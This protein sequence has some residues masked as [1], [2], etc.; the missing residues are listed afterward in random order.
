MHEVSKAARVALPLDAWRVLG[1]L[2]T[3][4]LCSLVL[5][6]YRPYFTRPPASAIVLMP[7]VS[8]GGVRPAA[9]RPQRGIGRTILPIPPAGKYFLPPFRCDAIPGHRHEFR[10]STYAVAVG[11]GFRPL[12]GVNISVHGEPTI[13]YLATASTCLLAPTTSLTCWNALPGFHYVARSGRTG[14]ARDGPPSMFVRLASAAAVL[15]ALVVLLA[16]ACRGPRWLPWALAG[17]GFAWLLLWYPFAALWPGSMGTLSR[18][19]TIWFA[20]GSAFLIS[21]LAGLLS[22]LRQR[23][24]WRPR[25]VKEPAGSNI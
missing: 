1:I 2:C 19:C 16:L 3:A 23:Q 6:Y 20:A 8:T 22:A 11:S 13:G 25:A 21:A 7:R 17:G 24:G 12:P 9:T 15:G 4:A 5:W 18:I 10:R 14:R